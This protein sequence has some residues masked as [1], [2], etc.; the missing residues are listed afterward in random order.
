L[1]PSLQP[2][3]V[4]PQY[5]SRLLT[6]FPLVS[7]DAPSIE[8][9]RHTST[10]GTPTLEAEGALKPEVVM[11]TDRIVLPMQKI[12][13]HTGVSWESLMDWPAFTEYV[14]GEVFREV[15]NVEN[16]ELLNGDGTAGHLTGILHT[17]GILTHATATA[18]ALDSIE[19]S[20][21]LLRNGPALAEP[22]L[23]VM[24]PTTWSSLRRT[25]DSQNRYLVTP[26]PLADTAD[27]IWGVG[28]L[29][30]TQIADGVAAL[31]DTRKMGRVY[32]RQPLRLLMGW[33]NDDF[34]RNITRFIG[35][36]RLNIAIERPSAVCSVTG[37]PTS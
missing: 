20:F 31:I 27:R 30:S 35:E 37:L 12:A 25:K 21:A 24:S 23:A 6:R 7:T 3:V 17:S 2:L 8:Y 14:Y 16:N 11:N 15:V 36:E 1:P 26:N 13:A 5:E 9:I 34:A 22:D 32:V 4:G 10:S 28:V 29:V 19:S 33:M 18:T